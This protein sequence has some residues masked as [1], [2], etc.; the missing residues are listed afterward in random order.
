LRQRFW[1]ALPLG[2]GQKSIP[3]IAT[4]V[5]FREVL[6]IHFI[7]AGH[8]PRLADD[9]VEGGRSLLAD[10]PDSIFCE[11][12]FPYLG[13]LELLSLLRSYGH[14]VESATVDRLSG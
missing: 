6:R 4:D 13:G 8:A 3:I 10:R 1:F 11:V 2:A 5:S 7:A 9:A 12:R 14:R